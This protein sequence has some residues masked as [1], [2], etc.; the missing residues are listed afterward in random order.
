MHVQETSNLA[1]GGK[2]ANDARPEL[3]FDE[4]ARLASAVCRT[5]VSMVML[6]DEQQR[7]Y[8]ASGA[9]RLH[10]P[11]IRA[12][13]CEETLRNVDS[14]IVEDTAADIRFKHDPQV[15]GD[16]HIRFFC[17]CAHLRKRRHS[18]RSSLCD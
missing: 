11:A 1:S 5:P 6:L 15:T 17:R 10:E 14:L 2:T 9:L 12:T 3:E 18:H 7:W 16:P 13:F 4:I 8:R